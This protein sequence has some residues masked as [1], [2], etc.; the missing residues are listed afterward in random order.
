[1][2]LFYQFKLDGAGASSKLAASVQ[3]IVKMI[4]DLESM[5]KA[6]MEFEVCLLLF[7]VD[8]NHRECLL[9]K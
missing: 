6:M 5:K 3:E 7:E 1:M 9:Q 2:S 4:F 8:L